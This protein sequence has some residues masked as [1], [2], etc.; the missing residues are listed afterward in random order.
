MGTVV[1]DR[2]DS[3]KYFIEILTASSKLADSKE[4][5]EVIETLFECWQRKGTVFT[6]GCGGSASTASHFAADLA[7]TTMIKGKPRFKA[8]SLVDNAP[9]VSAWTNDYGW[10]SIFREQLEPWL[11]KDDVLVGFSVHGGSGKGNAETWSENLISAMKLAKE[12]KT[13]IIG[14]S[15]FDG[16][17]MK[18]M[19]NTC[20]VVPINSE[21]YGTPVV[22]AMHAVLNHGIIYELKQRIKN[23]SL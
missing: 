6:M 21:A 17:V 8:V 1:K 12:R 5:Q 19:A 3:A 16:G 11:T 9:L 20:L 10:K 7:K 4:Y 15:G 14:F 13:K 2:F 18:K 22:E 23:A